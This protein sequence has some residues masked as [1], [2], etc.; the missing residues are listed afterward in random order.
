[1]TDRPTV[2][3]NFKDIEHDE[4]VSD[5]IAKR[6]EHLGEEFVELTRVEV[7]L[8]ENGNGFLAHAHVTGKNRD[9]GAQA[10]AS[11]LL[12]ATDRLLEKVEKQ[13]R[14]IHDKRIFSQRR[15]AQRHPPKKNGASS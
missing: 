6:S 3:T 5:L 13:L 9:V 15:E 10:E 14:K 1:M 12:P 2:V 8:E 7:T 4:R 11:E